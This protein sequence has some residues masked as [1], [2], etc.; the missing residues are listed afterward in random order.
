MLIERRHIVA[1]NIKLEYRIM[2][3]MEVEMRCSRALVGIVCGMLDRREVLR[4][5]IVRHNDHS[6]G[7]LTGCALY[8]DA[9]LDESVFLRTLNGH[10]FFVK[11]LLDEAVGGLIG[12]STDCTCL[13]NVLGAEKGLGILMRLRLEI[14]REVEVDIG[15]F[16]AV[17]TEECFKRNIVTV[18]DE[19]F[20]A[21]FTVLRRQ[22]EAR[23]YRAV[24]EE[25][26][27][28]AVFAQVVRHKRVDLG[29]PR[30][31]G[32]KRRADRSSRAD[33]IAVIHGELDESL[34]DDI[35][36]GVAMFDN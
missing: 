24:H 28:L 17:E 15:L 14:T 36:H 31:E 29:Y 21:N 33:I 6:A 8:S 20:A 25:C 16:I 12:E 19:R 32:D 3:R 1:E 11:P 18:A 7:V 30:R 5:F 27:L 9:A 23:A 34:S 2:E 22:V 10:A 13:E 4:L 35:K 26:T